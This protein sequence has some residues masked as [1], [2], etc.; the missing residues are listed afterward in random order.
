MTTHLR[1]ADVN[2]VLD[3][4]RL[5]FHAKGTQQL[6]DLDAYCARM[7]TANAGTL[8]RKELETC[9]N[10]FGLFPTTQE[11]G[12][13]VRSF[14]STCG[15]SSN[16]RWRN[17][18]LALSGELSTA[19][20]AAL[21]HAFASVPSGSVADVAAAGHFD[22]HPLAVRGVLRGDDV[23][24]AFV[25]GLAKAQVGDDANNDVTWQAFRTYYASVSLAFASDDEFVAMLRDVW[26]P[27]AL[28]VALP[29]V[30]FGNKRSVLLEKLGQRT[31]KEE[32]ERDV[33]L[34]A[35]RKHDASETGYVAPHEL[36]RAC[37]VLGLVVS[38]DEVHDT[39]AAGTRDARGKLS[40]AWFADFICADS[41]A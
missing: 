37:E 32:N 16:I 35:L 33:L 14:G 22:D 41:I 21:R 23:R 17:F 20:E 6:S 34:R 10:Y 11:I 36:Q 29:S 38:L 5:Q 39:F 13:L 12:V 27:S 4:L 40:I 19:R 2:D 28:H 1:V 9:L 25:V 3:R 18:V 31:H 26:R 8:G 30:L 7:D 15:S 24:H